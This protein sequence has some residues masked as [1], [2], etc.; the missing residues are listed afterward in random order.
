M[1][2]TNKKLGLGLFMCKAYLFDEQDRDQNQLN[3]FI[4]VVLLEWLDQKVSVNV[5]IL[6]YPK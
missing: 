1:N 5:L 3:F 2:K 4:P 6:T